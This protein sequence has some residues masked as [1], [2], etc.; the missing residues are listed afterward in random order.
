MY[1]P[2]F[3]DGLTAFASR[4]TIVEAQTTRL[5]LRIGK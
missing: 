4:A 3:L 1:T 2:S 5:D